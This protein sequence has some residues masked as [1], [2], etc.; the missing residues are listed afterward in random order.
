M[1]IMGCAMQ[2]GTTGLNI[3]RLACTL[4]VVYTYFGLAEWSLIDSVFIGLKW[5]SPLPQANCFTMDGCG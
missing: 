4:P 3:G 1:V 5:Q 2:Q